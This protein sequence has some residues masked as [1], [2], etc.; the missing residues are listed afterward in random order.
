[1][2]ILDHIISSI[3]AAATYNKH[4]VTAPSVI[5][6]PDGERLWEPV[7]GRIGEC[8]D[9]FHTLQSEAIKG[10]A[11][12][13]TWIRYNLPAEPTDETP[14][15]Y[16]PG[17]TRHQFR[18][19]ADFP[20]DARHVYALQFQGQFWT[21]LSAKD[22]TPSAV[23]ASADGGLGLDLARDADTISA[24][25]TQLPSL[26]ETPVEKLQGKRLEA[27]DFNQ[28][29]AG[30][31]Q[32]MMLRWMSAPD[33]AKADWSPEQ[34]KAFEAICQEQFG[35]NPSA[36]GRL[37]AAEKLVEGGEMWDLV[38]TRY[39]EA[40]QAFPGIRQALGLVKVK[41]LFDNSSPRIPRN[42]ESAENQLRKK[43]SELASMTPREAGAA[44]MELAREHSRRASSIWAQLGEAPLADAIAHLGRMNQSIEAGLQATDWD[45]FAAG[46]LDSAWKADAEARR[47]FDAV[48]QKKDLDAV[49]SALRAIYLPWLE[50]LAQRAADQSD[51]Y[52]N[53]STATARKFD[54]NPGTAYLFVDGLR[55]DLAKELCALLENSG[56]EPATEIHWAALPSV[57]A[58]AKP[59]W[60]PLAELLCGDSVSA[61][62]EPQL[63]S[64]KKDLKTQLFREAVSEKG[65]HWF[66][67]NENGDPSLSGWTEAAD[68]DKRGHSE[69]AK[70]AWRIKEELQ[71][72]QHR[73][74]ELIQAG[75]KRVVVVTDHGWLWMP[76]GLPK[77]DLPKHLTASKWGRCASPQPGA[78]HTLPE[79]PWFWGA[80]HPI[81][82]AP[83]IT[84]LK[85]GL[86]Y[87]HGGLTIQEALTVSITIES[88]AGQDLSAVSISSL[89]WLGLRLKLKIDGASPEMEVDIRSN[90]AQAE[91][92]KLEPGLPL[93][94][95]GAGGEASILITND[96]CDGDAAILVVLHQD[97]VICKQPVTVGEN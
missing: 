82:L 41:D 53:R 22:W 4:D 97:E 84:A 55:A 20:E 16:L 8:F 56:I 45:G 67:S 94:K 37:A 58:T 80:E 57:T 60:Q 87:A 14:V 29:A 35:L 38:W 12:P 90:A 13:S 86:E 70:L 75:W 83:G 66:A 18:S 76:G 68:F 92:T 88:T 28:L 71:V 11:G 74:S 42:N 23:L 30:D 7:A 91:S 78:V 72:V 93:P 73:I 10:H 2:T 5:L 63:E 89:R 62:F 51:S 47:S 43:L 40:P 25:R 85:N 17:I 21:Q 33:Q 61:G 44:A 52:P 15:V 81:V 96:G 36:D 27:A 39:E 46:Y 24:L 1:M 65:F 26:L 48:R 95:I 79:V 9:S 59:A 69:G 19:S 49:T 6:W 31:P 54:P 34:M 50:Q 64:N 77:T 32:G 3:R